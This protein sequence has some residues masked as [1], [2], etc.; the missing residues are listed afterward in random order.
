MLAFNFLSILFKNSH[1]LPIEMPLISAPIIRMKMT[2]SK[3]F[4]QGFKL[5][6]NG[7]FASA[8]D[9]IQ[10]GACGMI[11]GM[12]E[13]ALAFLRLNVTPHFI[14]FSRL[15]LEKETVNDSA[16]CSFKKSS[17]TF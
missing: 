10:D 1:L 8:K 4:E 7:V 5:L 13:P 9:I 17:L 6:E 3:G 16:E 14:Q 2:D 15:D 12:P 11:N